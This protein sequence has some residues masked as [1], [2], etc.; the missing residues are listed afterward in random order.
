MQTK[1]ETITILKKELSEAKK[2]IMFIE[3]DIKEEKTLV[4]DNFIG[5]NDNIFSLIANYYYL[6]GLNSVKDK[7]GDKK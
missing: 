7:E 2:M 4:Q 5:L 1:E 6:D 3:M